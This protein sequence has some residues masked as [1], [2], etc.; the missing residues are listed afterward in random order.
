MVNPLR[1]LI[2]NHKLLFVTGKGG[3][4][5]SFL[6][7]SLAL[8]ARKMGLKVLVV[9][10]ASSDHLGPLF[11]VSHVTHEG[12]DVE[13][14]LRLV[15]YTLAGNFRDFVVLHLKKGHLFEMLAASKVVHSFFAAIPGFAELLL[16]GRLYYSLN[17]APSKPDLVIVDSFASG[18][19]LSL[20]TTPN[21]VINSGLMGPVASEAKKVDDFLRDE[22]RTGIIYVGVLEDLVVSEIVDFIPK[23]ESQS[24]VKVK[25]IILN[26]HIDHPSVQEQSTWFYSR[27]EIQERS[28]AVLQQFRNGLSHQP[29]HQRNDHGSWNC[30][31]F[32]E[33]GFVDEPLEVDNVSAWIDRAKELMPR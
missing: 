22:S 1:K 11:G 19:F 10:H 30:I 7:A 5:K 15:N 24:P 17:L 26:R 28:L 6:S 16:L 13:D 20:M 4:G 8:E 23:L 32:P 3:I 27:K 29:N 31:A 14:G 25:S 21:A 18:H 2:L 33:L 12:V 9:Q